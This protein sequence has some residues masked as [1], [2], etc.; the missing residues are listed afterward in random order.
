MGGSLG[1][2]GEAGG[3]GAVTSHLKITSP[4]VATVRAAIVGGESLTV[5]FKGERQH[6][7]NDR[8]LIETVVCLAN[9]QGGLLLVGVEDDGLVTGA[10]AR[11]GAG[12]IDPLRV[13]ALITN[14]T[15]PAVQVAVSVV[16]IDAQPVLCI[17]VEN[18]PRIVGTTQGVYQRRT[19]GGDGRPT[20]VPFHAHEMLAYEIDRGAAD[21]S[22]LP[23]PQAVWDDLDPLEFDRL[24]RMARESGSRGDG[25]LTDLDNIDI[26]R[27]LGLVRTTG[28]DVVILAGALLLF[29]HTDALARFCPTHEA[30]IQVLRGLAVEVNDFFRWPLLRLA[31]EMLSRFRARN[32]EEEI[33]FG[34]FRVGVPAYSETAFREAL[35]NAL[36]HRDY[37]ARGAVHVQWK[38]EQL[39]ISNPGGFPSGVTLDNFLAVPPHPRNPLLADAFKRAGI[40]ERTGRGINRIFAEQLRFGHAPPDYGRSTDHAV[41][42]V[43]PGG[44]ADLSI[45]RYVVEQENQGRP[46]TLPDLQILTELLH[47]R[48]LTT[49]EVAG[50]LQVTDAEARRHLSRM[51]ER[52][53]VEARGEGKGRS[54]HLTAAVYRELSEPAAYVRVHGFEPLQQE[55]LV[56]NY[57]DAHGRITR[58]QAADLCAL[59]LDQASRL[60]RRMTESGS[61]AAHGDRRSTFYTR[62][63]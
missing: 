34:L 30:A 48:R 62:P 41:V 10:R 47:N 46:L 37:T 12:R 50:L 3:T 42:A 61:L 25:I 57:V 29:G 63:A 11:H 8:D 51:V 26:A 16:D 54:W 60:L 43:L 9:G 39:E 14:S 17:Q 53:L 58:A 6:R 40:V 2:D 20:C 24:R 22:T 31:E 32:T 33:Q 18:S 52:G 59:S 44:P 13:Q 36:I 49:A 35:A 4:D 1:P 21:Y 7:L 23:V 19:I 28:G 15:Q 5:E 55:Q 27:A 45:T 56:L 38:D